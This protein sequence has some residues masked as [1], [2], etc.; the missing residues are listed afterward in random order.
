[1]QFLQSPWCISA[2]LEVCL[3]HFNMLVSFLFTCLCCSHTEGVVSEDERRC[4]M[5]ALDGI[6]WCR[7]SQLWSPEGCL[8]VA[9]SLSLFAAAKLHSG[10]LKI[11]W[12]FLHLV[13]KP[14][15]A[16]IPACHVEYVCA[17]APISG[18]DKELW[19]NRVSRR[20][21]TFSISYWIKSFKEHYPGMGG[22]FLFISLYALWKWD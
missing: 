17:N 20:R 22:V 13:S 15:I 21:S 5:C 18:P 2:Q 19:W 4:G 9:A 8:Q 10:L 7:G 11:G 6:S 12:I 14:G 16:I 3:F 1:M